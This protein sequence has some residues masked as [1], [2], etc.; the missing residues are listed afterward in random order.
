[1]AIRERFDS[2]KTFGTLMPSLATC[3]QSPCRISGFRVSFGFRAPLS[4]EIGQDRRTRSGM[5]SEYILYN[6][7]G[8]CVDSVHTGLF[9][10]VGDC[11]SVMCCPVNL[12]RGYDGTAT[13]AQAPQRA[14]CTILDITCCSAL[15]RTRFTP[16]TSKCEVVVR[17]TVPF[18]ASS[19]SCVE[20]DG[21]HS[22][23][24]HVA[25]FA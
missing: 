20:H 10:I 5:H 1:M 8:T 19:I 18:W 2:C 22:R 12:G 15:S 7:Q 4:F 11:A 13:L 3:F 23:A 9:A 25:P 21:R 14:R 6:L 24:R 16:G 17:A